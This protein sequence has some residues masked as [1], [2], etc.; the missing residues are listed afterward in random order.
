M[1]AVSSMA[2]TLDMGDQRGVRPRERVTVS[3]RR[4]WEALERR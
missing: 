2:V 4:Q 1:V 3:P